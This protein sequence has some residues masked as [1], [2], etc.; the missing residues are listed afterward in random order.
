MMYFYR[1]ITELC[2]NEVCPKN[3]QYISSCVSRKIMKDVTILVEDKTN[4]GTGVDVFY[5]SNGLY[6]VLIHYE[7]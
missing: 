4:T 1:N 2:S 7:Q 5:S 3:I 6:F